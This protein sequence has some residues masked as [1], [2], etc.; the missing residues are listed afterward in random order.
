ME[1]GEDPEVLEEFLKSSLRSNQ[2]GEAR[3]QLALRIA[4]SATDLV[5]QAASLKPYTFLP[6]LITFPLQ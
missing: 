1:S 4:L 5:T 2:R 6:S 3:A